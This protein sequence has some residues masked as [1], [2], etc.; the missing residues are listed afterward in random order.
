MLFMLS[1]LI[2]SYL[3]NSVIVKD[4]EMSL[5]SDQNLAEDYLYPD[6]SSPGRFAAE[7]SMIQSGKAFWQST[8]RDQRSTGA[9]P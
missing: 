2:H 8:H 1:R 6:P 7:G 3:Y 9:H 5:R 4:R